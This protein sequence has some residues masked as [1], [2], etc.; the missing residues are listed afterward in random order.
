MLHLSKGTLSGVACQ[1][2]SPLQR[3]PVP[4]AKKDTKDAEGQKNGLQAIHDGEYLQ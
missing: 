1:R 4:R 2:R 3:L